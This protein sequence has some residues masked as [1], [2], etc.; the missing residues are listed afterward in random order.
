VPVLLAMEERGVLVDR[1]LLR[2]QGGEIA[3]RCRNW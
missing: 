3:L 1:E 2:V